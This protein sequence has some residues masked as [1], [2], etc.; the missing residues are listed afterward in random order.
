MAQR[1]VVVQVLCGDDTLDKLNVTPFDTVDDTA[2]ALDRFASGSVFPTRECDGRINT[3]AFSR[4]VH[5]FITDGSHSILGSVTYTDQ[6]ATAQIFVCVFSPHPRP[7][8]HHTRTAAATTRAAPAAAAA[9]GTPTQQGTLQ[10]SGAS[11]RHGLGQHG[12]SSA[13]RC[14]APRRATTSR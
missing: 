6:S 14:R 1:D 9:G 12:A 3:K 5:A 8:L 11:I 10:P 13:Q 4:S 7:H 2:E